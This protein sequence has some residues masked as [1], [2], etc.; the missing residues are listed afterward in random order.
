MMSAGVPD[1][2]VDEHVFLIGR[3]P[4]NEYLGFIRL[5]AK[6]GQSADQR[7]LIDEW[8][9]AN[10]HVV[11]LEATEAGFA[12]NPAIQALPT[13]LSALRDEVLKNSVFQRA[14]R[15]LPT[16]IALVELDK[17][18]VFQKF[19]NLAFV[20]KV[21]EQL[22]P[23]PTQESI[24]RVAL[25]LDRR[26]PPVQLK[27]TAGNIYAFVSPSNDFRFLEANLIDP[28][29]VADFTSTGPTVAILALAVGYGSNYLSA[30]H[31]ENRLVLSNGSHRAFALRDLGITHAP[32]PVQKVSRRDEIELVGLEDLKENPDRYLK[33]Q[34]PPLLKDYFDAQLR[35]A[36][37]VPR[38]NRLVRLSFGYEQ[39]DI[40]AG[41]G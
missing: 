13:S 12:D 33:A 39:V 4:I 40:P 8:R 37:P 18:V 6:D 21:K 35:K 2:T 30:V 34:R 15:L 24:F 14:F 22:G 9:S 38:K 1:P 36:I 32:C 7:Q 10:D 29:K 41:I 3:P 27:Q 11:S 28:Q 23:K 31:V 20:A 19:I 25:S 5:M 17:L 26:D 16:E